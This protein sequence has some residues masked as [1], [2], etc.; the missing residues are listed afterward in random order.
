MGEVSEGR[1][2]TAS[3]AERGALRG[4]ARDSFTRSLALYRALSAGGIPGLGR[5]VKQAEEAAA[6]NAPAMARR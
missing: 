5:D 2:R 3:A 1:A 4:A 6:R